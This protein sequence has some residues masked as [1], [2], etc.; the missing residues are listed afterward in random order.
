MDEALATLPSLI[1]A[2]HSWQ[3]RK[4]SA[5]SCVTKQNCKAVLAA[6]HDVTEDDTGD[7]VRRGVVEDGL[8][9][10]VVAFTLGA[11]VGRA[12]CTATIL[13]GLVAGTGVVDGT[14]G[15]VGDKVATVALGGRVG[16]GPGTV[17]ANTLGS[18]VSPSF[19][20]VG[21]KV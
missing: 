18:V 1:K 6:S 4:S 17:V 21:H 5:E 11:G 15:G 20:K 14:G 2:K 10:G 9:V 7:K 12:V 19:G 8:G 13:G 3:V 16:A